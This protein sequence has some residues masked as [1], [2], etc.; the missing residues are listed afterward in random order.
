MQRVQDQRFFGSGS[1]DSFQFQSHPIRLSQTDGSHLDATQ[2]LQ[3]AAAAQRSD[4]KSTR[5]NSSHLGISYAVFCLKKKK[6]STRL[7]SS[8]AGV[9]GPRFTRS[10]TALN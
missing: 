2:H 5:L 8:A 1:A 3:H 10:W 9:E 7:A 6:D 4:R